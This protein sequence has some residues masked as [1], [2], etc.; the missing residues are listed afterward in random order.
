MERHEVYDRINGERDYQDWRWEKEI[1]EDRVPDEDKRPAEWLN[2][3]KYHL[4]QAEVSN[5]MLKKEETMNEIRKIAA[6]AVRAMEIHGCPERQ[7]PETS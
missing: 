4:E 5:Y 2:Y 7:I 6:L 3:I 1:R